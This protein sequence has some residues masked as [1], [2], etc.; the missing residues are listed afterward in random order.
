MR[1]HSFYRHSKHW[2]EVRTG[3]LVAPILYHQQACPE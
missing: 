3:L 2:P 1:N